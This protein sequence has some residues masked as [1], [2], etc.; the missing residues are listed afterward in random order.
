MK[1]QKYMFQNLVQASFRKCHICRKNIVC[2]DSILRGHLKVC[3]KVNFDHYSKEY[4]LNKG[5]T[6]YPT[7]HDF[8][9]NKNVF[10][11]IRQEMAKT[12]TH[13]NQ[14]SDD[15]GLIS[16]SILSSMIIPY[17]FSVTLFAKKF[18]YFKLRL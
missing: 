15:N 9:K 2:D 11:S 12:K 1:H 8:S 13:N 10:D 3:H 4:V 16:P 7:F 14:D 5:F 18:M 6:V 17:Y